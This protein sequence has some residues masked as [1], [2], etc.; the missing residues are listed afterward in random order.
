MLLILV[1]FGGNADAAFRICRCLQDQYE[2]V[3][4]YV[5]GICKSAGTLLAVGAHELVISDH[6]ELGPL[7]VQMLKKDELWENQSGL[8]VL[9]ALESLTSRAVDSFQE[10]F[11]EI[12]RRSQDT[13]TLKTATKI[14]TDMITGLFTPLYAQIDPIHIGEADRAMSIAGEYGLKLLQRG[15]NIDKGNLNRLLRGYPSHGFVID[16]SEAE[17][18]FT[19]VREPDEVEISLARSLGYSAHWPDND[20][21]RTPSDPFYFLSDEKSAPAES[22]DS[23]PGGETHDEP[24]K[25]KAAKRSRDSAGARTKDS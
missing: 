13:V 21:Q 10:T 1:T 20:W 18:L 23:K 4:V 8:T 3:I 11:L 6:G 2:K 14:S 16:R 7:D 24:K 19:D 17:T 25:S 5:P 9:N 12:K 15:G 22:E